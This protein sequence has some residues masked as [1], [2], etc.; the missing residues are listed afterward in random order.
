MTRIREMT[1]VTE[2][3][4]KGAKSPTKRMTMKMTM[5]IV[6]KVA[7]SRKK[8]VKMKM[9]RAAR[10]ATKVTEIILQTWTVTTHMWKTLMTK[11]LRK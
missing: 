9:K 7:R 11:T 4:M 1:T 5:A 3:T 2:I 8:I 6:M 10:T